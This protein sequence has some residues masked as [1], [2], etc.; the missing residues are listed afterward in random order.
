MLVKK[1]AF[2]LLMFSVSVALKA[3]TVET[4]ITN[5]INFIGGGQQWKKINSIVSSGT[6]NYG[7][8]EF[9][10]DSYSKAPDLYKYVV[11]TNGKFFAQAFDGKQGWKIDGF[12]GET[13]KTILNGKEARSMANEADVELENVFINYKE[14]GY[15]ALLEGKDSVGNILCYKVKL[16]SEG[17]DTS[18]YF[19]SVNDF[20]LLKKQA[21]SKNEELDKSMLDTYY[22]DYTTVE[23]IKFPFKMVSKVGDQTILTITIKKLQL[24]AAID[25]NIF[26]P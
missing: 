11:S 7:G 15:S 22:S 25:D 1:I 23:G 17:N 16:I 6:Y 19:F 9:P 24:N 10:F 8:M 4:V 13:T 20:S 12:K 5:Y 3:Q 21:V 2:T 14:K 18:T 26:K